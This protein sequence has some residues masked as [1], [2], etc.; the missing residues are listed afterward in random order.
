[1][2]LEV[3]SMVHLCPLKRALLWPAGFA[4]AHRSVHPQN[5]ADGVVAR[6]S[7]ILTGE[8][9]EGSREGGG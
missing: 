4:V 6:L 8:I 9:D 7:A 2:F 3:V 1:M 5:K